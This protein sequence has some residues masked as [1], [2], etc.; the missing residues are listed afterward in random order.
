MYYYEYVHD[1][2]LLTM[3]NTHQAGVAV[4]LFPRAGAQAER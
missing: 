2:G 3:R 1:K 4:I